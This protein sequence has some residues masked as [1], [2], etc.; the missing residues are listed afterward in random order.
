MC[1]DF[2]KILFL[3]SLFLQQVFPKFFCSH[4]AFDVEDA[5]LLFVRMLDS[6]AWGEPGAILYSV[7]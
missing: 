2:V 4:N 7:S 3:F 6:S 5:I 1:V